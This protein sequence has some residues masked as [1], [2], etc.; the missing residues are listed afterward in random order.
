MGLG[1]LLGVGYAFAKAGIY[2]YKKS[3]L[4]AFMNTRESRQFD[5]SE[6]VAELIINSNTN[7]STLRRSINI[8]QHSENR[9]RSETTQTQL[10]PQPQIL[11]SSLVIINNGDRNLGRN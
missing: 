5:L 1:I 8:D 10:Q 3:E 9:I 11:N 6:T 4:D 2:F 7:L